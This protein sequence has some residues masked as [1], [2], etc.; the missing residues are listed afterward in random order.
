MVKLTI[1]GC[2]G[3]R[4]RYLRASEQ[5][6]IQG[7]G[8]SHH[9]AFRKVQKFPKVVLQWYRFVYFAHL[10]SQEA[11]PDGGCFFSLRPENKVAIE[12][13]KADTE[14]SLLL[15]NQGTVQAEVEMTVWAQV[16]TGWRGRLM[17]HF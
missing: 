8:L 14:F 11:D 16:R 2:S 13:S 15:R 9:L 7:L 1:C 5:Q 4:A 12:Q 10:R 3:H 17:S 6:Y